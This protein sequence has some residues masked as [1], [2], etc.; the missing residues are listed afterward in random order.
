MGAISTLQHLAPSIPCTADSPFLT[1]FR[2]MP[3][4]TPAAAMLQQW[5]QLEA[6]QP[7]ASR[8]QLQAFVAEHF[9]APGRQVLRNPL[10][11][12]ACITA[13]SGT[14]LHITSSDTALTLVEI[15]S[16]KQQ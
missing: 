8:E 10:L 1:L 13:L 5:R 6:Q 11:P 4:K 14:C 15:R 2:D 16:A 3:V 12:A 7:P 9:A